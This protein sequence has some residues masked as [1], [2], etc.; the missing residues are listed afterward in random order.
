[1]WSALTLTIVGLIALP[2]LTI[3]VKLYNGP[4]ESWKHLVDTVLSDYISNSLLLIIGTTI[5]TLLFGVSSAWVVSRYD[6]RFRKQLEWLLIL[7]LAIPSYIIAYAYAG[8]FDYGGT[9]EKVT[10]GLLPKFD[11]M[12]ITG[13][14]WVL[15][16]SLYPYV[17]VAARTFFL[18][19]SGRLFEASKVLGVGELKALKKLI[20][21]LARP[22]IIG[23]LVL[24]LM[25]VLNDYGAAKYYGV[26]TFTTG[27]FRAW[28]SLEE[29][30]TAIYLSALLVAV[31]F[32]LLGLERWQRNKISYAINSK[33]Q[34][35]LIRLMPDK[36]NK[37]IIY[38]VVG[39]PVFFGFLIPLIQLVYWALLTY[40]TVLNDDFLS[41]AIQSFLI[42]V[43]AAIVTVIFAL[44]LIYFTKWNRLRLL[45]Y[46]TKIGTLGYAI[47]GAV[48]AIG[49]LI[50]TLGFD[51]WLISYV[52]EHFQTKIG[53]FINGT[54]LVLVYAY[55]VRFMAV[56]HN[57]IEAV[58]LKVNKSMSESS[59]ILGQNALKTFFK[60]ELPLIKTGVF[61]GLVLVFVD[62]MKELPLT[63]I[64]KPYQV[65]TL[66]VKA[67]EYASDEQIME[68]ALPSLLIIATGVL[69]VILLNKLINR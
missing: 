56:A 34:V 2:I 23:G 13:L 18:N 37:I 29:P 59:K 17:Y 68:A 54:I 61:G 35:P 24:V 42:A 48:I 63:L 40:E 20:I 5:L 55:T 50:P 3:A 22:A 4:G 41:T 28:F 39:T 46:I 19:Q 60:I 21:P 65:Q 58:C 14:I 10:F 62:V 47:P 15:S 31:I 32:I 30:E 38:L 36:Q 11:V 49:V 26:S 52:S 27:I 1:M 66:A 57:P 44:A 9:I 12:N 64:L 6:F 7:P 45:D 33:T 51:K 43:L 16:I 67:Y 69:P 25:E 8:M 53:F